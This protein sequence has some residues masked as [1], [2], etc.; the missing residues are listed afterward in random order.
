MPRAV[1]EIVTFSL[2]MLLALA[3]LG[4]TALANANANGCNDPDA[5]VCAKGQ[6]P[7]DNDQ[8]YEFC[9]ELYNDH[10]YCVNDGGSNSSGGSGD[11]S[12]GSEGSHT[13]E[14]G[15][16]CTTPN[17]VSGTWKSWYGGMHC[18]ADSKPLGSACTTVL[19]E[20]GVWVPHGSMTGRK[21]SIDRD[22][23]GITDAADDCPEDPTNSDPDCLDDLVNCPLIVDASMSLGSHALKMAAARSGTVYITIAIAG[24]GVTTTVGV[25]AT[26]GSIALTFGSLYCA[27]AQLEG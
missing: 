8:P 2:R 20:L 25:A 23:D 12:V 7:D 15:D 9:M 18:E 10:N 3:A 5:D 26:A 16:S 4:F 24:V 21:C 22:G 6:R 27:V 13:P 1:R 19:G 17:G 11:G 14:A